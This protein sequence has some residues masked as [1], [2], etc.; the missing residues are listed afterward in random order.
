MW[1]RGCLSLFVALF[2]VHEGKA[3]ALIVY[4]SASGVIVAA[5]SGAFSRSRDLISQSLCKTRQIG[6]FLITASGLLQE[7]SP[8]FE[9]FSSAEAAIT[10]AANPEFAQRRLGSLMR[11]I[12]REIWQTHGYD[13]LQTIRESG[14]QGSEPTMTTFIIVGRRSNDEGIQVVGTDVRVDVNTKDVVLKEI[15]FSPDELT[16]K[17]AL[18]KIG[19]AARIESAGLF[20]EIRR[21]G[22]PRALEAALQRLSLLPNIQVAAPISVVGFTRSSSVVWYQ[23]GACEMAVH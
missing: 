5:D 13:L 20:S 1:A 23:R 22:A 21:I 10:S 6:P 12:L 16:G 2:T 19:E 4:Q 3:T 7:P 8:Q 15:P 14:Y 11:G 18:L 9:F 17:G